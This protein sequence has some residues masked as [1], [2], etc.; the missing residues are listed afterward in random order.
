LSLWVTAAI[1]G[2]V[3][4]AIAFLAGRF[5]RLQQ[6]VKDLKRDQAQRF[7]DL[8]AVVIEVAERGQRDALQARELT[9]NMRISRGAVGTPN[10]SFE[11]SGTPQ[12]ILR[13]LHQINRHPPVTHG[14]PP[15]AIQRPEPPTAW[16]RISADDEDGV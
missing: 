2:V 15:H 1:C 16:E 6:E 10:P 8:T 9:S 3:V 5:K 12:D 7:M 14:N 11:P 4:I 13:A